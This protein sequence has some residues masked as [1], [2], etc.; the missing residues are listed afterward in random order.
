[1]ADDDRPLV[2]LVITSRGAG[3]DLLACI[4]SF[5]RMGDDRFDIIVA[6]RLST[7]T[8]EQIHHRFPDLR[9]ERA[10]EPLSIPELRAMG[11]RA[12]RGEII[13]MTT[14]WCRAGEQWL[15]AVRRA[16]RR[17][18]DV[19][20][21][22][23]EY[24]GS[25]R[26]ASRAMFF[27]EYGRYEPPFDISVSVDLPGQNVSYTRSAIN[28]LM[29][30]IAA[31]SWEPLWHWYLHARGFRLVRDAAI[32]VRMDHAFTMRGFLSDRYHYSRAFAAQRLAGRS[33]PARA[34][35]S[36]ATAAL[37]AV[38]AGRFLRQIL[39][40]P[41]VRIQRL[42][43]MPFILLFSVPWAVGECV[44]GIFGAG[45]SAARID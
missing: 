32:L 35:Y 42:R 23:I 9:I 18:A 21:G 33:W 7:E 26:P 2:S 1:M 40:A 5:H 6:A 27:C 31:G 17:G 34:L 4:E 38:L 16:H 19:V 10:A 39:R 28:D 3:D 24:A 29:P 20:G 37:P 44:G 43:L 41:N 45:S 36:A 14:G 15:D 8:A 13:A 12:A 30:L 11:I 22:A 25:D